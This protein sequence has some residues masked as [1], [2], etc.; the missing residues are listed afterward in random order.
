MGASSFRT[1]RS[2]HK[3]R[4]PRHGFRQIAA[5]DLRPAPRVGF[6]LDR[7]SAFLNGVFGGADQDQRL[8]RFIPSQLIAV[9][10]WRPAGPSVAATKRQLRNNLIP[11]PVT[12]VQV[13][14]DHRSTL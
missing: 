5:A 10:V 2:A 11:S 1:R 12:I 3:Q 6:A 7:P 8:S 13:R 14:R 4:R 9:Q